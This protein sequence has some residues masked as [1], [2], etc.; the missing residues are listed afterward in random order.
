MLVERA[1]ELL[2]SAGDECCYLFRG[3]FMV[4]GFYFRVRVRDGM[5]L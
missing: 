3:W 5:S 2:L 1:G 4:S